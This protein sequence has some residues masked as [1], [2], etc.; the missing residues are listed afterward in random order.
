MPGPPCNCE[1]VPAFLALDCELINEAWRMA[2]GRNGAESTPIA[3]PASQPLPQ[4]FKLE[5]VQSCDLED[6][7]DRPYIWDCEP[8]QQ[9]S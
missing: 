1:E 2:G 8:C 4:P 7:D 9:S 5:L 3:P 6:P